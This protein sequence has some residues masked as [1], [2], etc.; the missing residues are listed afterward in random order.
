MALDEATDDGRLR[1][2]LK[3]PQAMESADLAMTSR[4][5]KYLFE[6]CH[7]CIYDAW[8]TRVVEATEH[9]PPHVAGLI[10]GANGE[11]LAEHRGHRGDAFRAQFQRNLIVPH[12]FSQLT[13]DDE[14]EALLEVRVIIGKIG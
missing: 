14:P 12:P 7:H 5:I 4:D 11:E 2:V 13:P 9:V 1:R 10:E 3:M 8:I 6:S